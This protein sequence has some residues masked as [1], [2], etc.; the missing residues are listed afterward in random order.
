MDQR[1]ELQSLKRG[2]R[3]VALINTLG[4]ITIAELG[5]RLSLPRTNAERILMTLLSEGYVER[6]PDTKAFFLTP[7]VHALSDGYMTEN[8]IV[9][10]AR[11][12]MEQTTRE[13]GWP[14]LLAT[15]LGEYMSVQ[16][17]T[18]P[19]TSLN[20]QRRHIG[21]AG[22][23]G[24]LSSGIVFLAFLDDMQR[25]VML[26]MLR[27]SDNPLQAAVHDASRMAYVFEQT[28]RDGFSFG[29]DYGRER[30]VSVPIMVANQVKAVLLMT[31]M[32]RVLTNDAVVEAFVPRLKTMAQTIAQ[33]VEP[34]LS[35]SAA[36]FAA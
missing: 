20:L 18:D 7:Q 13:I 32:A 25:N 8:R 19:Q 12:I 16:I 9:T 2:L 11:P 23:M 28:R 21:S 27:Q 1:Q 24:L 22:P 36:N 29:L 34:Q 6:D 3:T 15:P 26:E 33:Q 5:R 35:S 10:V 17:T 4:S 30:S 31:F 14:L